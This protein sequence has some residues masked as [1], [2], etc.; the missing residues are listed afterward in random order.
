MEPP[1]VKGQFQNTKTHTVIVNAQ[2]RTALRNL[3]IISFHIQTPY[4]A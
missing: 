2:N 4:H 3:R 1:F